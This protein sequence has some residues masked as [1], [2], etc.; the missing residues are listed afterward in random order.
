MLDHSYDEKRILSFFIWQKCLKVCVTAKKCEDVKKWRKNV[1]TGRFEF[2]TATV[3]SRLK[4]SI[5]FTSAARENANWKSRYSAHSQHIES[6]QPLT[7]NILKISILSL[8][9]ILKVF[10]YW[11]NFENEKKSFAQNILSVPTLD[12]S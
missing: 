9:N 4:V 10:K 1:K 5:G 6:I 12:S 3:L 11:L 2:F 8:L 7:D